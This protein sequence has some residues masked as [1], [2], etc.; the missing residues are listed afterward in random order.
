M[1]STLTTADGA[2]IAVP[3][4]AVPAWLIA[5][6]VVNW[7]LGLA[8]IILLWQR[9][10]GQYFDAVSLSRR[11]PTYAPYAAPGYGPPGYAPPGY[12]PPGTPQ[13]QHYGQPPAAPQ[14]PQ[15]SPPPPLV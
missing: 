2:T 4:L 11:R 14:D 3:S 7:L 1:P 13:W 9:A 12:A 6:G 5:A 10:A 8:I 15:D